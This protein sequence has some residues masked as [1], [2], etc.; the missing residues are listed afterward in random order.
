M[1]IV[2]LS[3]QGRGPG[4]GMSSMRLRHLVIGSI[5]AA[6]LIPSTP[7]GA[8]AR[9]CKAYSDPNPLASSPPVLVIAPG[10]YGPGGVGALDG[11]GC[12]AGNHVADTRVLPPQSDFVVLVLARADCSDGD[13]IVGKLKGL[14]VKASKVPMRCGSD[15]FGRKSFVSDV[16]PLNKAKTGVIKAAAVLDRKR[17]NGQSRT[18]CGNGLPC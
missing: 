9:H 13:K 15:A 11:Y 12:P 8:V 18:F 17:Y 3:D 7:G 1:T 5:L 2:V 6:L 10:Y 4:R 16:Y 14:G